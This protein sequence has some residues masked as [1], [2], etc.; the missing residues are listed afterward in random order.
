MKAS[1]AI[2]CSFVLISSAALSSGVSI[3]SSEGVVLAVDGQVGSYTVLDQL[4]GW[5][6]E[7][8][9]GQSLDFVHTNRGGDR[10]GRYEE[11]AFAW[12]KGIQLNGRI[13][14]YRSTRTLIFSVTSSATSVNPQIIFP[15]FNVLPAGLRHFSYKERVFAPP[16][17]ALEENCTP[18]LLFDNTLNAVIISPADNFLVSTM[19]SADVI[20]AGL[21][22]EVSIIPANFT[23]RT[24]MVFGHGISATWK[25]WGDAL[26]K[27]GGKTRPSNQA[28]MGLRYLGYWT[29]NGATYYYN[30]DSALGYAGTLLE[31]TRRFQEEGIPIRYLQ[32]DSWWYDKSFTGP[33]GETGT[34]KNPRLPGGKWNRYGGAMEYSADSMLFPR[35]L[36][37]FRNQVGIPLITHNRWIDP[38]S[39]YHKQY[40]ISGY[41]P[42]DPAWWTHI[43]KYLASSGVVCY[44]QDWL[45]EIFMHS[46]EL[47]STIQT[48]DA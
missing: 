12:R 22:K 39:P 42:V 45:S 8:E 28:D 2:L 29:D 40:K 17:F 21:R 7:G 33:G 26:M 43:M 14:L 18:W 9:I 6:F 23:R 44:E 16:S 1:I 13:R 47:G 34:T 4:T 24:I 5:K 48:G 41:A 27:L 46:P 25:T 11:I 20:A 35:G 15:H 32:L 38:S 19:D 10:L 36:R 30:Y 37:F 3:H 31:V